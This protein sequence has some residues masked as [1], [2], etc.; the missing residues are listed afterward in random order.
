MITLTPRTR[1][2]TKGALLPI[3]QI[4]FPAN[5]RPAHA[6]KVG[7]LVKSIRLIGLQSMPTVIER[8]GRYMLVAGRHRVEAMRVIGKDPIPVRIADFDDIEARL[9]AISENLHRNELTA[10][11]RAEQVTEFARLS[12]EKADAAEAAEG[13]QAQGEQGP[14]AGQVSPSAV[15]SDKLRQVGAKPQ[16]GRPEGGNR[17]AARD[18][19]LTEQ[20]VRRARTIATLP[21]EV[22][23][24]AVDLGLDRNQSALLDTAK[25][26]TREAQISTLERRAERAPVPLATR[27]S[28]LRNLKNIA[29][30][31]LAR[32]VKET[33]PNDRTH[34]I[35]VLRDCADFLEAELGAAK[36]A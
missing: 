10:L 19:G 3:A 9:W 20:E 21:D 28:S 12:Q 6:D 31:E 1:A 36:V 5:A 34:V 32:W 23:A 35:R 4:D 26:P 18:L 7:E 24:K 29:A 17:A 16:G 25:A 33:T 13:A 30:G 15:P 22:K 11:E 27:P 2:A 8:N 14:R